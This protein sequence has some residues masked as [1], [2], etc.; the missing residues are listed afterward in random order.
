MHY[1]SIFTCKQKG[2]ENGRRDSLN[3][4]QLS[5]RG[6]IHNYYICFEC[7]NCFEV[8]RCIEHCLACMRLWILSLTPHTYTH[9]KK[10]PSTGVVQNKQD[11]H[12]LPV[13]HWSYLVTSKERS[14]RKIGTP[15][16][17]R[18]EAECH[19][20]LNIGFHPVGYILWKHLNTFWPVYN[21]SVWNFKPTFS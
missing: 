15:R 8:C 7:Y 12:F 3:T 21:R 4:T 16:A 13:L 14:K 18:E 19:T 1:P 11:F 6:H 2:N 20:V 10:K 9:T 17:Q 5:F